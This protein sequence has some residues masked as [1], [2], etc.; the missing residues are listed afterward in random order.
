MYVALGGTSSLSKAKFLDQLNSA[1]AKYLSSGMCPFNALTLASQD[2]MGNVAQTPDANAALEEFVES[3]AHDA[4]KTPCDGS[5]ASIPPS[6]SGS[7]PTLPRIRTGATVRLPVQSSTPAPKMID[8]PV[9]VVRDNSP[10]FIGLGIVVLGGIILYAT[11][12]SKS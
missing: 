11:Y 2:V 7:S 3:K 8:V 10:I 5:S 12:G 4:M 6:T 9:P 1:Y